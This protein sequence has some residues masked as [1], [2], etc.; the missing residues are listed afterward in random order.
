MCELVGINFLPSREPT[1]R[2]KMQ[3]Y[4][5][6]YTQFT[7]NHGSVDSAWTEGWRGNGGGDGTVVQLSRKS[8]SGS[9][10]GDQTMD[11]RIDFFINS[12]VGSDLR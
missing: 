10:A 12:S 11:L 2:L 7:G 5:A 6:E 9:I 1:I 3:G 8:E 4:S